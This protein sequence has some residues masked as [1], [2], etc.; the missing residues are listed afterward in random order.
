MPRGKPLTEDQAKERRHQIMEAA[1]KCFALKGYHRTTMRDVAQEAGLAQGTI[2]LYFP[3]KK[4]L[5]FQFL[6]HA[7]AESAAAALR[8]T[9]ERPAAEV[10]GAFVEGRMKA[11]VRTNELL[12]VVFAEALVDRELAEE[13]TRKVLAPTARALSDYLRQ[14]ELKG[15]LKVANPVLAAQTL[16]AMVAGHVLIWGQIARDETPKVA[17]EARAEFV[18]DFFL[19]SALPLPPKRRGGG[20]P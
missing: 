3:S 17:P 9:E 12:K 7:V 20:K 2:Y 16:M 1:V 13:L 15:T 10:I 4:D 18:R 11:H 19:Q 14:C 6:E 8:G 5:L